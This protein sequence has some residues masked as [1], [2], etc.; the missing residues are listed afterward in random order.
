M[1]IQDAYLYMVVTA[2]SIFAIA[3]FGVS[4]WSKG[5]KH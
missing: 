3:V 1:S 2:F 5:G 4:I